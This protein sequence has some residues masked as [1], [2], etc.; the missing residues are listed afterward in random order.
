MPI[1]RTFAPVVA[2]MGADGLPP[3]RLL[4]RFR[5]RALG[6]VDDARSAT[7]SATFAWVRKNTSRSSSSIVIFLSILPGIVAVASEWREEAKGRPALSAVRRLAVQALRPTPAQATAD[8]RRARRLAPRRLEQGADLVRVGAVV[9]GH[10]PRD[11]RERDAAD[12]LLVPDR[13]HASAALAQASM[14]RRRAGERRETL[15]ETARPIGA[16]PGDAIA[17]EVRR[18]RARPRSESGGCARRTPRAPGPRDAR[19]ARRTRIRPRDARVTSSRGQTASAA[20]ASRAGVDS[21]V[22]SRVSSLR[23]FMSSSSPAY[24]RG[25]RKVSAL[26][27]PEWP[28]RGAG[29]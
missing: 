23:R 28:F 24:A 4:Q 8:A 17:V 29:R 25:R 1:I 20:R 14:L 27:R 7:S 13:F 18:E 21:S 12:G 19:R 15:G 10:Q 9:L 26:R 2:G 3:L 6:A 16:L 22:R 5:R 11:V